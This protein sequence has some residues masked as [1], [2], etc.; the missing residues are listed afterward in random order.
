MRNEHGGGAPTLVDV[1]CDII[2]SKFKRYHH[3]E[4]SE[5][6]YMHVAYGDPSP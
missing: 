1:A 4:D 2:K 3:D 6:G 5:D